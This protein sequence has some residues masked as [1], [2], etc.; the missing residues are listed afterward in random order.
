MAVPQY[1]VWLG[2]GFALGAGVCL[3]LVRLWYWFTGRYFD[4]RNDEVLKI[5][6][7]YREHLHSMEKDSARAYGTIAEKLEQMGRAQHILHLE[8]SNLV[9]ALRLPHVRGRWGEMTLRR[10]AELAGMAEHCDFEEQVTAG[11][12]K[13][14][15][16]PDMIINLPG[17]RRIVIDAKVPL[18]AYLDALEA[19]TEEHRNEL[20]KVHA[21]QVMAHISNLSSRK[22]FS[23]ICFSPEFVILFIPGE[24]FFSA[25][26]SAK[27]DLIE[28]GIEKGVVLATPTTLIAILKAVAFSW[29]Q[30]KACENA[31]QIRHLGTT[32]FERLLTMTANINH[33][34]KEIEKCVAAYNRTVGSIGKRVMPAAKKLG[35][36]NGLPEDQGKLGLNDIENFRVKAFSPVTSPDRENHENRV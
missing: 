17:S 34:G 18:A 23:R 11:S 5:I 9:K 24:N 4:S 33:L 12:G 7:R 32:L 35:T 15:V 6:E 13:G 29:Q 8:T 1:F 36:L 25:A 20:M 14:S 2:A 21:R 26:L 27:P 28:K 31:E 22:Y 10:V 16:R 30:Q 3:V 19:D